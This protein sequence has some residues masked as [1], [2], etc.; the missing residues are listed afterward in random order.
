MTTIAEYM[1][2]HFEGT[3]KSVVIYSGVLELWIIEDGLKGK[4]RTLYVGGNPNGEVWLYPRLK[5]D[6]SER[7]ALAIKEL[8]E[9]ESTY[10]DA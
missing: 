1:A 9:F 10:S 4:P 6:D 7:L 3:F 8:G 2:E 5:I